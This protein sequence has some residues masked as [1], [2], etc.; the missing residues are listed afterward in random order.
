MTVRF[1]HFRRLCEGIPYINKGIFYSEMYLFLCACALDG[2][3]VVYESG[4]K[5]GF[6]T[7]IMDKAFCGGVV[8]SY[9]L[10]LSAIEPYN[11]LRTNFIEGDATDLI[12][13]ALDANGD[14]T[15]AAVL[16]DGPKGERALQ[17][18]DACLKY[19]C[20]KL[21]GVHDVA[22][23]HGESAHS[24][25]YAFRKQHGRELDA[26]IQ[27]EY[28]L[29]YPKGPGLGIWSKSGEII[30]KTKFLR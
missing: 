19:P 12:P 3:R 22:P 7:R 1:E 24:H 13:K 20:C 11:W 14:A 5:Y 10:D 29:K 23:G 15:R 4:V 2:V 9:D 18:K 30:A 27:G 16:I 26:L 28:A 25:D 17:L 6:S 21:V 8:I